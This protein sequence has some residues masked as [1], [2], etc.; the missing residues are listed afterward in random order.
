MMFFFLFKEEEKKNYK[1]LPQDM[2]D[3]KGGKTE[4]KRK[5][6]GNN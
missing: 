3:E 1:R 4:K 2:G 5:R 6:Y